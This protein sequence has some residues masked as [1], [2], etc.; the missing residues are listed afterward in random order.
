MQRYV[1]L[2]RGPPG[3]TLPLAKVCQSCPGS[4]WCDS[5]TCWV[6]Q[7]CPGSSSPPL[8]K[9]GEYS[10]YAAF[11]GAGSPCRGLTWRESWAGPPLVCQRGNLIYRPGSA[12]PGLWCDP[13]SQ[14]R[15]WCDPRARQYTVPPPSVDTVWRYSDTGTNDFD[16][17]TG[18]GDRKF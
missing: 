10:P 17:L 15:M 18:R 12:L 13:E 4:S 3:V 2:A 1:S 6:C 14:H 7:P 5:P 9:G 8:W 11:F 16:C